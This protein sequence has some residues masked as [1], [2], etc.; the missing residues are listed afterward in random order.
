M[1][2][3]LISN[4][5]FV[6][7]LLL[8]AGAAAAASESAEMRKEAI[9]EYFSVLR[10]EKRFV[11][12]TQ[13]NEYEVSLT[14]DS[15]DRLVA[16]TGEEQAV[17]G[18]ELMFAQSYP[19]YE[20]ALLTHAV[21]H[22]K[23]GGLVTLAWHQ[24][25]PL[26]VCPRGEFYDCSKTPMSEEELERLLTPGTQEHALWL[27]DVDAAASTLHRFEEAGVVVLFRPYHEMNGDWFWWGNKEAYPK[28]WDALVDALE[29]KSGLSNIIWVWSGDR[30]IE[31]AEQ[32]W[33]EK[34][35]PDIV[36]TDVYENSGD[37]RE[38]RDGARALTALAPQLPFGFTEVGRA[39]SS[40]TLAETNPSLVLVWGGEYLNAD[41]AQ[42]AECPGC[43]SAK[44]TKAFFSHD[45]AVSLNEIPA[46]V[47]Q[48][49]AGGEP[50]PDPARPFCPAVLLEAE[51]G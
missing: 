7:T 49:I 30:G 27:A 19:H 32:Y 33:P 6:S 8:L 2:R 26:R 41:W 4:L 15:M 47:R 9:L 13:V 21:E 43:N 12:G 20:A 25:N 31:N 23:R 24:R 16:M 40:G 18:L 50:L 14:C 34:F 22:T 39:P 48:T 36:G 45:N 46:V 28:L 11:A 3:G 17:L 35:R 44:E 37:A 51:D 5:W 1:R 38:Y 42:R 10:A 29:V